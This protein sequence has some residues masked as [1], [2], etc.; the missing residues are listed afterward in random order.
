MISWLYREIIVYCDRFLITKSLL[1]CFPS[2]FFSQYE[3]H[4]IAIL[5]Q[6][7]GSLITKR[8][9]ILKK[10]FSCNQHVFQ[11]RNYFT[12][13]FEIVLS[14]SCQLLKCGVF[15]NLLI[16]LINFFLFFEFVEKKVEN[17]NLVA[18]QLIKCLQRF[19]D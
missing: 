10:F 4:L 17:S 16:V 6:C 2:T 12:W 3:I 9:F 1:I 19:L 13:N 11:I 18:K 15:G 14:Y 7:S 5:W 8:F